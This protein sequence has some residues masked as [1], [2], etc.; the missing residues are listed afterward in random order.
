MSKRPRPDLVERFCEAVQ[1]LTA[2][3][4]ARSHGPQW[5]MVDS[6]ARHLG[7]S[8]EQAQQAVAL[9]AQRQWL[10]TDGSVP[11]HRVALDRGLREG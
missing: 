7:I 4:A 8:K 9:A 5:I 11:P 10:H 3:R 6:V 2:E 1:H